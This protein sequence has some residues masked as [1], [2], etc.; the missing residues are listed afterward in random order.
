MKDSTGPPLSAEFNPNRQTWHLFKSQLPRLFFTLGLIALFII[1]LVLFEKAG[2]HLMRESRK[3]PITLLACFYWILLNLFAQATIA[4]LSL[5]YSMDQGTGSAGTYTVAGNVSAPR[6]DCFYGNNRCD[7]TLVA[8]LTTA[9]SYGE[10]IRGE[11]CCPYNTTAD[12]FS[13][14]QSCQYFCSADRQ[15][16][17]YR[18]NEYNPLDTTSSYPTYSAQIPI[19][20]SAGA[21]NSTTYVYNG[22]SIPQLA[23]LV[24][25][26]P[27]CLTMYVL[28]LDIRPASPPNAILPASIFGCDISVTN[29]TNTTATWQEYPDGMA[30][31]AIAAIALTGRSTDPAGP[32]ISWQQYQLY[33]WGNSLET[34]GLDATEIGSNIAQFAIGSI[35][36]TAGLNQKEPFFSPTLPILGYS[37]SINWRFVI[38]LFVC[39]SVVHVVLVGLL[40]W[41]ARPVVICDDS[42][43]CT[44][45]LL[46]GLVGRIPGG[47]G[48][49][50]DG[51]ALARA[52]DDTSTED[53]AGIDGV[54]ET[55][56]KE[57]TRVIYG[58]VDANDGGGK[59]R[60][61][62]GISEDIRP[63]SRWRG[64]FPKGFYA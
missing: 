62:L 53:K 51:K 4:M 30:R 44:A 43:L 27:R 20:N 54:S 60:R 34:H 35:A 40:C 3:K 28:R 46:Q 23:T 24:A 58:V 31:L 13:A 36:A 19:P 7:L 33:P 5:N 45:R 22:T 37:P 1:T 64:A 6:L 18:F 49:L 32:G 17:A 11:T 15:E 48:A 29:V 47:G 26:G 39:I 41:V 55:V 59:R 61:G 56:H 63:L 10:L 8:P 12:I 52:I 14:N 2:N 25:C 16:F 42:D 9:H 38:L 57:P 50:L 21:F